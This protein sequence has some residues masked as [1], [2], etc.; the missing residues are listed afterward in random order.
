M[1]RVSYCVDCGI[2]CQG[3]RCWD[4]HV[5]L[6]RIKMWGNKFALGQEKTEEFSRIASETATRIHTKHGHAKSGDLSPTY[7][8]WVGMKL[9]CLYPSQVGYS[10]YGGRG[11]K[12]CEKWIN[13]QGF[14][15]DMGVRPEGKTLDRIDP[16]GNYEKPNC[17][18]ATLQEQSENKRFPYAVRRFMENWSIEIPIP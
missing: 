1:P 7:K 11:I 5:P 16:D 10:N 6:H 18:W 12:I 4:C 17:R 14:L 15:E 8:T 9:R 3:K 13:F 2:K